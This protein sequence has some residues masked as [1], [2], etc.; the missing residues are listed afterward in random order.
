MESILLW[1]RYISPHSVTTLPSALTCKKLESV[2]R[3]ATVVANICV[4]ASITETNPVAIIVP[5]EPALIKLASSIGVSGHGLGDLVHDEKVQLEVLKQMQVAGK[6]AGLA[7]M[8]TIV[9]VVLSDE[10]WTPQNV[11]ALALPESEVVIEC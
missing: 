9:G 1:K 11:S 5:A 8:E 2:Y 10:E 7:G 6:R 3:S 4:Y